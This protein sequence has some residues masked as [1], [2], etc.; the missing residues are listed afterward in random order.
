MD[1][2]KGSFRDPA[3]IIFYKFERVFRK[4]NEQ[5]TDR[6]N[7]LIDNDLINKSIESEFLVKSHILDKDKKK[8]LVLMKIILLLNMKEFHTFRILMNGLSNSLK[9]QQYI[10]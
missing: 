9:L 4:I 7:Y 2:E 8:K 6:I 10:T 5:G 3:A 1:F